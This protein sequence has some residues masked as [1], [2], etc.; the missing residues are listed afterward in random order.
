M[1]SAENTLTRSSK[2]VT[3]C[4]GNYCCVPGCTSAFYDNN[5]V[6]TGI[7]LFCVPK[8]EPLRKAWLNV[9][10]NIRRKSS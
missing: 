4:F 2:K 5:R 8:R 6:K 7:T 1:A 10:K 3:G 9:L